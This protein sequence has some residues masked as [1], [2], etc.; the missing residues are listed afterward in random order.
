LTHA[1]V[2]VD[3][4]EARDRVGGRVWSQPFAG[5]VVERG[6]EFVLP[7]Y[8]EMLALAERLHLPLTR[9]GM[10]YGY[11]EPR[12]AEPVTLAELAAAYARIE[13]IARNGGPTVRAAL[14][15]S[16]LEPR[17]A[18]AICARLEVSC[19]YPASDLDLSALTEGAGSFGEFDT[20][21]VTGGNDRIARAL[22]HELGDAIHLSTP[23]RTVACT[24]SEVHVGADAFRGTAEA[25]VLTVPASV[26]QQIVFD[27]PL[28]PGKLD[29]LHAVRYGQA[30][31]LFVKLRE[32]A[33]PS[34]TLSVPERYW[35]Y[36]QLGPDGRPLPF[37]AA[38]A[39]TQTALDALHVADGPEWWIKRIQD[40]RPDLTLEPDTHLLSR[41]DDDLWVRAAYSARSASSPMDTAALAVPVGPLMFAGEHT[42]GAWH[43]LMEGALR[44]G[45]RAAQQ[46]LATM[47]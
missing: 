37:V 11:R 22:A 24:A 38:F 5:G 17:I 1:G 33:P 19:T 6:A 46:L 34:A 29:A 42:A 2:E 31:K 28:P 3:V 4:L 23:V 20:H 14:G 30:A 16:G 36:T 10:M 40:L 45:R 27:P 44:S 13:T 21:T 32:P 7:D 47:A 25:A 39:G 12:G 8:T 43:G 35:C 41:W 9:K 26:T 15:T 18:E